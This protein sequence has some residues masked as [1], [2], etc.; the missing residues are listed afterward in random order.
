MLSRRQ[1]RQAPR[2]M[3]DSLCAIVQW[4][5]LSPLS[6]SSPVPASGLP[7]ALRDGGLHC[8]TWVGTCLARVGVAREHGARPR[9]HRAKAPAESFPQAGFLLASSLLVTRDHVAGP[10]PADAPPPLRAR[11]PAL[12]RAVVL[13][14]GAVP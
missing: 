14:R 8:L 2:A 9:L 11:L 5:K 13:P 3:A 12:T 7:L 1:P 10:V 4:S 6:V